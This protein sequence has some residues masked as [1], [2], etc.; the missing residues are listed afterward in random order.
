LGGTNLLHARHVELPAPGG[1]QI[2]RSVF[3]ELRWQF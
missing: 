2:T 1:E 3:A